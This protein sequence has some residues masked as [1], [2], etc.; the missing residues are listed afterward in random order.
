MEFEDLMFFLPSILLV[1]ALIGWAIIQI[2]RILVLIELII[3]VFLF[4]LVII[5]CNYWM[6]RKYKMNRKYKQQ[7]VDYY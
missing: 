4:I 3:G 5:W 7:K 1:V 2:N 6:D